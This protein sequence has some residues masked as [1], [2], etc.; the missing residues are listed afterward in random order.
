MVT[1]S[2][3]HKESQRKRASY[4]VLKLQ[5]IQAYGGRCSCCGESRVPFLTLNHTL[6]DG[7]KHRQELCGNHRASGSSFLRALARLGFPPVSGLDVQC[8]N[9]HMAHDL[10]GCCPHKTEQWQREHNGE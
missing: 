7:A 8:W 4:R 3:A 6:Q 2:P 5:A 9:C 1:P 10:T